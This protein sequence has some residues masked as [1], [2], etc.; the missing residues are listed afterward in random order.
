MN[1]L[2]ITQKVDY[3][4][5]IL[6]F[7]HGWIEEISKKYNKVL[8]ICLE[9][10]ASKLP[11]NTKVYSLGKE[12][13][14]SRVKYVFNFYKYVLPIIFGRK[15]DTIFVH[16]NEI[17]VL[18]LAPLVL[19]MKFKN[20]RFLWWKAHGH[21][22]RKSKLAVNFVDAILTSSKTGFPIETPKRKI[23]GQGIDTKKFS[24]KKSVDKNKESILSVGRLSPV[25]HVED[26]ILA[27]KKILKHERA[28]EVS[29]IGPT[30]DKDY[31]EYLENIVKEN[32]LEDTINFVGS[33]TQNDII[34]EYQKADVLVNTSDTDSM[35]KVVLEAMSTGV[36]PISSN[37]AYRDMLDPY[38]L[39]VPK[40]DIEK[41]SE[42]IL[43]VINM[44]DHNKDKVSNQM[45]YEV[46]KNHS[47]SRLANEIYN[48]SQTN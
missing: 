44:D 47:L 29:V 25:K 16:M 17:Y 37:L 43:R 9:K 3:K 26:L 11:S 5:P 20:I 40:R 7:F 33:L 39:F 24:P 18:L 13:G 21:L 6:G 34:K 32:S 36:I 22:S 8:I 31:V 45:R 10:G 12:A 46:E 15:T 48:L 1:I 27:T 4:D 35:D 19:I 30:S 14:R 38:G 41:L 28:I 42:T 23:I 2:I